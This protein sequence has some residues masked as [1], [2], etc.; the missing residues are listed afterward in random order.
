[1]RKPSKQRPF[2]QDY[3]LFIVTMVVE[4]AVSILFLYGLYKV[5]TL[6]TWLQVLMGLLV[7]G[8]VGLGLYRLHRKMKK[9]L[10]KE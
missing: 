7:W 10:E 2:W 5:L 8:L 6:P 4:P 3:L 1:M 9:G